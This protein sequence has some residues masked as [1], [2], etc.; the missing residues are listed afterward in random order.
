MQ[1]PAGTKRVTGRRGRIR[2]A[3]TTIVLIALLAIPA[4]ALA[5]SFSVHATFPKSQPVAGKPWPIELKVTKG[6]TKLSGSVKYKFVIP[7]VYS[8]TRKGHKFKNGMYKDKLTFPSSSVGIT[9]DLHVLVTT[10]YGTESVV[11]K[12]TTKS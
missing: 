5:S 8:T 9:I 12:V 7:G 2:A 11:H 4:V 6:K 10:K 1:N 3:I